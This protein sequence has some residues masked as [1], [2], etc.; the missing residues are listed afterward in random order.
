[1]KNILI[2]TV[3]LVVSISLPYFV[4]MIAWCCSL[5]AFSYQT[6]V[7]SEAFY[8]FAIIYWICFAWIIPFVMLEEY[9]DYR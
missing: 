4:V 9:G 5:G 7:T 2:A 6:T 8:I 1:M 3:S